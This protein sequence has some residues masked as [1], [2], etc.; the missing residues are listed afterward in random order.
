VWHPPFFN[1]LQD[2]VHRLQ[3]FVLKR[4]A[5]SVARSLLARGGAHFHAPIGGSRRAAPGPGRRSL[6][7]QIILADMV[8]AEAAA[9]L[10]ERD[11]EKAEIENQ[12]ATVSAQAAH[13]DLMR[14]WPW[15]VIP[16]GYAAVEVLCVFC[17]H[18][19]LF[20]LLTARIYGDL[21]RSLVMRVHVR[22]AVVMWICGSIQMCWR[23][24]RQNQ[25]RMHRAL[26]YGFLLTWGLLV[27]PTACWLSLIVRGDSVFG[28]VASV[29]LLDVTFLS[30]FLFYRAWRVA[31]E[32]QQGKHSLNLHG[33]IMGLACIC[34]MIQIPQRIIQAGFIALRAAV[35]TVL[36]LLAPHAAASAFKYY[37]TH[38]AVFG[39]SM[40][41][42]NGL[43][44][45]LVD[46]PRTEFFR[47][48][49]GKEFRAW[50]YGSTDRDCD[51]MW[52]YDPVNDASARWRWRSRLFVF[53]L[54]RGVITAGWTSQPTAV[55]GWERG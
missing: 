13:Q 32:R 45:A 43:I 8:E 21:E 44:L 41:L 7:P 26:G 36:H 40:A 35:G 6:A 52:P 17:S 46:G 37:V 16:L 19:S 11:G 2:S 28:T 47:A 38:E 29:T 53:A 31:R 27:G 55:L 1:R 22:S 49:A 42:G 20:A 18:T 48:R 15:W 10:H 34:T 9:L 24:M 23:S 4:S 51:E 5:A 30:Y 39:L 54:A 25:P 14:T 12:H 50:A 33:N 3:D